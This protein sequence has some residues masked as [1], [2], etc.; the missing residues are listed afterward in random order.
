MLAML[1]V[2]ITLREMLL[3]VVISIPP[4]L[5]RLSK[6]NC[7]SLSTTLQQTHNS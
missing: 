1:E 7:L 2:S 3:A 5:A 4:P 6:L